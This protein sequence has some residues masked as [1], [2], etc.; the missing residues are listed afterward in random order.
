MERMIPLA[1][2]KCYHNVSSDSL[3]V[4][5]EY[6]SLALIFNK[7]LDIYH[8]KREMDNMDNMINFDARNSYYSIDDMKLGSITVSEKDMDKKLCIFAYGSKINNSV[9]CAY[10]PF[11]TVNR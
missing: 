9:G 7:E 6:L 1:V 5:S 10:V 8:G 11:D 2:T 3:C 4:L